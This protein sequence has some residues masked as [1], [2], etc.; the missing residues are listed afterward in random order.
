MNLQELKASAYDIIAQIQFLQE[1]LNG[2][3]Q[4]ILK[5]GNEPEEVVAEVVKK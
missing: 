2:L 3:N 5:V 4:Q 1:K